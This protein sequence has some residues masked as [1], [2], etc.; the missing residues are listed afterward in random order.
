MDVDEGKGIEIARPDSTSRL[1]RS[2]LV[3]HDGREQVR[4]KQAGTGEEIEGRDGYTNGYM[5]SVHLRDY[6]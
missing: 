4:E 5:H 6:P 3:Y 2:H 1:R